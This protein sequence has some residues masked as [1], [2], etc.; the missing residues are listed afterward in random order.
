LVGADVSGRLGTVVAVERVDVDGVPTV[1]VQ[2]D[3]GDEEIVTAEHLGAPGEDALPLVGDEAMVQECEGAGAT[4]CTGYADPKNA[5]G[6]QEGE[7]RRYARDDQGTLVCEVW[8]K[9]DGTIALRSVA[10]G[11]KVDLNG[12]LIDQ[13]GNLT[14][15]GE[16]TA[17]A[18]TPD[19]PLPGVKLSTH[20]HGTGV[21]PTTAPTPGT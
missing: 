3:L 19:A 2:V 20:L 18:G 21:G 7:H 14:A 16:I 9:R 8:L 12:V 5:G 17:M 13:Q 1:Q 4:F 11:S 15:P 10:A 6:A